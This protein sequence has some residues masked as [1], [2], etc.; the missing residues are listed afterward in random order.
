MK[1][2]FIW[3]AMAGFCFSG[4]V[5]EVPEVVKL[6][7]GRELVKVSEV[8]VED[9]GRL[10]VAHAG[11]VSRH[12]AKDVCGE[13]LVALGLADYSVVAV[14]DGVE[15]IVTLDGKIY[16]GVVKVKVEPSFISFRHAEG[17][18]SVRYENLPEDIRDQCGYDAKAAA[19]H[20]AKMLALHEAYVKMEKEWERVAL[21]KEK[22]KADE[23]A[24]AEMWASIRKIE[25]EAIPSGAVWGSPGHPATPGGAGW[26]DQGRVINWNQP[27]R[28]TPYGDWLR[29]TY[30]TR[31][32]AGV[33][34]IGT[35]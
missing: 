2:F 13:T 34:V 31:T 21:K 26:M 24:M 10:K 30:P 25:R 20:D 14:L 7:D 8:V 22:S 12:A 11:G 6:V 35:Y 9:D 3:L 27:A 15:R 23:K 18:A 29:S 16:E 5:P 28:G 17:A 32:P 33:P 1:G 4:E 19:A